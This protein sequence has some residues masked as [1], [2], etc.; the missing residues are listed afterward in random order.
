MAVEFICFIGGALVVLIPGVWLAG[1][2]SLGNNRLERWA[3]GSSL[4]LAMAVYVASALSHVD[5]RAFYP[6]W[7]IVA[8]VCFVIWIKSPSQIASGGVGSIQIWMGLVLLLVGVSRFGMALPRVLPAGPLDPTFQMILSKQIQITHHAINRWP[9]ANIP[10]NY[11]T[12]SNVLVVVLSEISRL[13]LHTTFKDL[14]P[15]LGVLTTAQMYVFARRMTDNS[16]MALYSAAIYGLWA[17]FGSIDYFRWGGLPNELAMLLFIT[18][19][20]I[21]G[22]SRGATLVMAICFAAA[23]LVH[24]HVMVV[25]SCILVLIIAW[26]SFHKKPWRHLANAMIAGLLIDAFFLVPYA[27]HLANFRATGMVISGEPL[28]PLLELAPQFGYALVCLAV[29]GVVLCVARKI[30]CPPVVGIASFALL[31]MFVTGEDIFPLVLRALHRTAFTFFT[32]SRFLTDLN[33]FLPVFAAGAILFLQRRIRIPQWVVMLFV[34]AAPLADYPRWIEM[35]GLRELDH[36]VLRAC[37][38]IQHNTQA[39][40]IV[41]DPEAWMTYLCWREPSHIALPVSEPV[42]DYRAAEDRIPRILAGKLPPDS[43]EMVIVKIGDVGS[44]G[45]KQILWQDSSGAAVLKEWP[46]K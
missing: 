29:V 16:L 30:P 46:V 36:E 39:N 14:I 5:L 25:S 15:L 27:L 4:G 33:Y 12:G 18:M 35:F 9:F 10:L 1:A 8:L 23:V 37:D 21:G 28:L 2:L 13:P 44:A 34:L 20:C 11:P 7:G 3:T 6:A 32:P 26:Q 24:H 31:V 38:W 40:T 45:G 42:A 43:A 22:W 41:D 17:W 19:L